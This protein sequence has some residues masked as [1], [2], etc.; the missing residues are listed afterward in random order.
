MTAKT[1]PVL[2]V[3]DLD[4]T[5]ADTA[6]D[7]M[8]TLDYIMVEEGFEKTPIE[9]ARSLLGAG[10]RAL[11]VR[12][13]DQQ[14]R[15]VTPERLEDMYARFLVHYEGRIADASRLY[16][17]VVEALDSLEKRGGVFAVCTN[18][19]ERPAKLLLEKLGVADRFA[20]ICGQDTFG[21]A[22]PDPRPL[23]KTIEAA[24]GNVGRA[25]MVGDSKTD[26]ATAR[27]AEIPVIAVD[28]GYTD[29]PVSEYRPDR[30]I[31]HFDELP[32]AAEEFY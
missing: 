20:F 4:G 25:I 31:S 26:I 12:A 28:F 21:I 15:D 10:A 19:V 7:L 22:K 11:L 13:L 27:A 24:G 29:R 16:P 17:G 30:I 32:S 5:L 1:D 2:Y 6:G 8:G 18:K 3:F 23:L 14:G 9:D